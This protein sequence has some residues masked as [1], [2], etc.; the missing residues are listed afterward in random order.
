MT[1][2]W[3]L[4]VCA[5]R[6]HVQKHYDVSTTN[7]SLMSVTNAHGERWRFHSCARCGL[8]YRERP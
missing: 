7:E 8:L 1:F 3:A 6:G 5:V 2:L 4:L